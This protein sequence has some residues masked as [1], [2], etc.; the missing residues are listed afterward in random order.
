[1]KALNP[2]GES[3]ASPSSNTEPSSFPKKDGDGATSKTSYGRGE[4]EHATKGLAG[5][6]DGGQNAEF[7]NQDCAYQSE[8]VESDEKERSPVYIIRYARD[9]VRGDLPT[10]FMAPEGRRQTSYDEDG[11][12]Y[13]ER[14][15]NFCSLKDESRI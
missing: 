5:R 13:T 6:I 4:N 7:E 12:Q 10:I 14:G 2:K 9:K 15:I 3:K 8:S 1:M 11:A